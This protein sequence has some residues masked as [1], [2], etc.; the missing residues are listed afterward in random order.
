MKKTKILAAVAACTAAASLALF[1]GCASSNAHI[2]VDSFWYIDGYEG[3]QPT[4]VDPEENGRTA[5]VLLYEIEFDGESAE[6]N[7]YRVNYFTD[8]ENFE[9]GENAHYFKT[10]FYATTFDWSG[11]DVAEDYRLTK[12]DADKLPESDRARLDGTKETV[13]VLETELKISGEYVFGKGE[14]TAENSVKFTDYLNTTSYFRSARNG[15]EPVYSSQQAHTTSPAAMRPTSAD[16]MCEELEYSY[17]VSYNFDCSQATYT[18]TQGGE[19]TSH[20]TGN[21]QGK[22]SLFDNN[23]LYTAI[24][25]MSIS[26]SLGATVSLFS[27]A[28]G[29]TVNVNIAG[30]TYGE[31]DADDDAGIISALTAAYGEPDT[32][33]DTDEEDGEDDTKHSYIY[34]NTVGIRLADA[35]GVIRTARYAAVENE[36]DNTYRAT[37]LDLT[38]P[39]S[40]GL[41]SWR[42][43]L[44]EV[45]SVLGEKA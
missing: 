39:L 36:D 22:Y 35:T 43:T 37:M 34:Y 5:E 25:G 2:S 10:T 7:A 27:P 21:I 24:R 31:L 6:N 18:F 8:G 12:E 14:A 30:G 45:V 13:Y 29:G 1:S 33:E 23:V 4:S 42:F 44:A 28:D 41:G 19:S 20:T 16:E 26:S 11:E 38:Q 3:I 32:P 40:Y 9:N 17:E 15:L